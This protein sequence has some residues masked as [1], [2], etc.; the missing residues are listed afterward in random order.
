MRLFLISNDVTITADFFG[1]LKSHADIISSHCLSLIPPHCLKTLRSAV[2]HIKCIRIQY[3]DIWA[4]LLGASFIIWN[5]AVNVAC[6]CC[7][8]TF[9]KRTTTFSSCAAFFLL[10]FLLDCPAYWLCQKTYTIGSGTAWNIALLFHLYQLSHHSV[11]LSERCLRNSHRYHLS[12]R[13]HTFL[14]IRFNVPLFK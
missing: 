11:T 7:I 2:V 12:I 14:L 9:C 5:R 13:I 6:E 4:A 1:F 8:V 3:R 10:S